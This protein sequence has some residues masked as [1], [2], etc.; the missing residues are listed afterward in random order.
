MDLLDEIGDCLI[1][2]V[3]GL[4]I[5]QPKDKQ[6]KKLIA[7]FDHMI[8][9]NEG[10]NKPLSREC[11]DFIKAWIFLTSLNPFSLYFL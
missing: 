11:I 7:M 6:V 2:K 5:D 3:K 10:N 9:F 1:L 8:E 4:I